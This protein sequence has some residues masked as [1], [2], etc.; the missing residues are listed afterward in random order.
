MAED[1]YGLLGVGRNATDA[2][3][4]SAYRKL[5][6]KLHPDRNPG[7]KNAEA[8]FKKVG[9]AYEALSDPHKRQR[10][11]QYGEA[12]VNPGATG[13]FSGGGGFGRG[14][15]DSAEDLSDLFR[16]FAGA[17]G[18]FSEDVSSDLGYRVTL[19]L[20]EA[21][22][23]VEKEVSGTRFELCD[24]C[25]GS[26]ATK[27]GYHECGNCGGEGRVRRSMMGMVVMQPC[28]ECQGAGKV[29]A[30]PCSRC[31]ARGS[32]ERRFAEKFNIRKGVYTGVR[33]KLEGFGHRIN[34]HSE[35]GD[36]YIEIEVTPSPQFDRREDDL[37]IT[38]PIDVATAALGGT[39]SVPTIDGEPVTIKIPSGAQTGATLRTRER[40][41]PR[42]RGRGRGDM[43]VELRVEVP[44]ELTKRQHEL[45]EELKK[46]F[47]GE[48][49]EKSSGVFNKIFGK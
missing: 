30:H 20:E 45:F 49:G 48:V 5:A 47:T 12:G 1:Y 33:M 40:G 21:F 38:A 31:D 9:A 43:L 42:L 39:V 16:R 25:S 44:R 15:R 34:R 3:I 17:V 29:I 27:P 6:M 14:G 19:T 18:G 36:I 46:T 41:M 11:D 22:H 28:F 26:G 24:N 35:P 13:G 7:D 8:E 23:G 10:Y 37:M 4:K 2:E 32:V